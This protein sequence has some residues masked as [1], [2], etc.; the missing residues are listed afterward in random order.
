MKYVEP[1]QHIWVNTWEEISREAGIAYSA[2]SEAYR[3]FAQ[4]N[5]PSPLISGCDDFSIRYQDRHHPNDDIIKHTTCFDG[6]GLDNSKYMD[7][8]IPCPVERDKCRSG[9]K[10][11]A[12]IDRFSKFTFGGLPTWLTKWYVTNLDVVE[13]NMLWLP[14]GLN[15]SGHGSAVLPNY[16]ERPKKKLLYVNFRVNT[17]QREALVSH[18]RNVPW[19]TVRTEN[20]PVETYLEEMADHKY[21]LSPFGNGLDCYRNYEAMYLNCVP[22]LEDSIFS[23]HMLRNGLPVGVVSSLFALN[24]EDLE[25]RWDEFSNADYDYSTITKGF[26]RKVFGL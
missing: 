14:F 11:V 4:D 19:A 25:A 22:I 21:V 1:S 9:D 2:T 12:K 20:V 16:M 10:F 26:W 18:Y 6:S 15:D 13:D 8:A 24:A 3:L 7:L 5:G 23:R 17:M